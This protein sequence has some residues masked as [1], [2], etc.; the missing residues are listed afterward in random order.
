MSERAFITPNKKDGMKPMYHDF[1][2]ERD[3][4]VPRMCRSRNLIFR[5][6]LIY[7]SKSVLGSVNGKGRLGSLCLN[8]RV[9]HHGSFFLILKSTS[10]N[11][12]IS[13]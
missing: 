3:R 7:R 10:V 8:L 9:L 11:F 4:F 1:P 12:L 2:L 5:Q 13:N 6:S